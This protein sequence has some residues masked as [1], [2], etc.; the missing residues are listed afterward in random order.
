MGRLHTEELDIAY[1]DKLIVDHL[2]IDLPEGKITALVGANGSGK[3]TI[4]RT[5]ARL[6]RP[7]GGSV[8]L[9]GR[10]IHKQPTRQVAKQLAILP[11]NP[12]APGG[13]TVRE[14]ISYGRYPHQKGMQLSEIDRQAIQWAIRATG[15]DSFA[16]RAVDS[17]SGGQRQRAWIAMAIAQETDWL[18]LD[19]PTTFL[20]M[21]YQLDILKLIRRL[22]RQE[23]RSVVMVVHDL[24]HAIRFADH[25]IV[26]K[27]GKVICEGAPR[28]VVTEQ[29]LEQA[30]GVKSDIFIDQR[31][32]LP[33]C[34]PYDTVNELM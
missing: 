28:N 11:Q 16:D 1:G 7:K 20:D 26:I 22:N 4:L 9:D 15:L 30:F 17:L 14:L 27:S 32:Q 21:T 25:M 2:T 3:S 23:Q 5:M 31:T 24:N 19:E 12:I 34:V 8:L 10:S 18:F 6:M 33:L 13:V 29:V